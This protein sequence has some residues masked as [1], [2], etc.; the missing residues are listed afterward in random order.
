MTTQPA[1]TFMKMPAFM[2]KKVAPLDPA[3]VAEVRGQVAEIL[4]KEK[5]RETQHNAKFIPVARKYPFFAGDISKNKFSSKWNQQPTQKM[6]EQPSIPAKQEAAINSP[7][8]DCELPQETVPEAIFVDGKSGGNSNTLQQ[9][10]QIHEIDQ[11]MNIKHTTSEIPPVKQ[12]PTYRNGNCSSP[13]QEDNHPASSATRKK[14]LDQIIHVAHGAFDAKRYDT[15]AKLYSAAL[16]KDP[17]Q[18]LYDR[19]NKFNF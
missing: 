10:N 17:T 5:Q 2:K 8:Q 7:E 1:R 11:N 12:N 6:Q 15:A 4:K 13:N 3:Y 18:Y 14:K 19:D 16:K 9:D